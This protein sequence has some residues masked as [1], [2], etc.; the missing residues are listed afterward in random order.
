MLEEKFPFLENK[1]ESDFLM[2]LLALLT[3]GSAV[4]GRLS[5]IW[6]LLNIKLS[7]CCILIVEFLSEWTFMEI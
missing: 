6:E 7:S 2:W 4:K 3:V 1:E 5:C